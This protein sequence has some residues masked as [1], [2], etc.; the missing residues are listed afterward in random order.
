MAQAL[1]QGVVLLLGYMHYIIENFK[2]KK[3]IILPPLLPPS[4][5]QEHLKEKATEAEKRELLRVISNINN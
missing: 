1:K 3:V 2:K 5:H 4:T